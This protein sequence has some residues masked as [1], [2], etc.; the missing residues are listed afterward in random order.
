MFT[1]VK[2]FQRIKSA[3]MTTRKRVALWW[4]K[5]S[6]E[7]QR[8]VYTRS[9]A[10]FACGLLACL[11]LP[12]ASERYETQRAEADF[13]S[14]AIALASSQTARDALYAHTDA[15]AELIEHPWLNAVENEIERN[16]RASLSRAAMYSRDVAAITSVVADGLANAELAELVTA[17][18]DCLTKAVYYEAGFQK[19]EGKLAVAEVIMNRVAD[20]RYP[21]SVCEVVFQGA[22]RT[23]GCQF[24]FTCDG[25]LKRKPNE[26]AYA[27]ASVVAAHVLMDLHERRTGT[28]TH[29]HA[30]Y[31]DP[32]W[33]VGLVRTS[34]IGAHIFYRF[35]RGSEWAKARTAVARKQAHR[36]RIAAY[37]ERG[38][39]VVPG[40]AQQAGA[41]QLT[42][43]VTAPAP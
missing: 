5:M 12:A 3:I 32:I 21:N 25:A 2:S 37:K 38:Y 4:L 34:K 42:D 41:I 22:T 23:T 33:N 11:L 6:D 40:T 27:Q 43:T 1:F 8:E 15:S 19:T 9:A 10:V 20:H 16:P 13:R 24:T 31:V 30:T 28:A 17:E 36:A 7:E 39:G 18:H 29:Y 14:Q 35:P 26:E